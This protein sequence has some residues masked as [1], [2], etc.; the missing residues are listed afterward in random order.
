MILISSTDKTSTASFVKSVSG[1]DPIE[2][3]EPYSK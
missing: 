2:G 3:V 1:V